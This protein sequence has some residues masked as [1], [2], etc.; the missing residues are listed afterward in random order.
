ME[1]IPRQT[2]NSQRAWAQNFVTVVSSNPVGYALTGAQTASYIAL[3]N[4]FNSA[5]NLSGVVDRVAVNPGTYTQPGRGSLYTAANACMEVLSAAA[6]L[7]QSNPAISDIMKLAAGVTPRNFSRSPRTL[8]SE[9]PNFSAGPIT[10]VQLCLRFTNSSGG[11]SWPHGVIG[12]QVQGRM[13]Q[14]HSDSLS[15]SS[16]ANIDYERRRS[17]YYFILGEDVPRVKI[18]ARYV[19]RRSQVGPWS[20]ETGFV[21]PNFVF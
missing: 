11:G 17:L 9:S 21:N 8:P 10:S 5:F 14:F 3:F 4:A 18:Q 16:P 13:G 1:S 15:Y 12:I 7:I 2:L 6:V 19:G 20:V